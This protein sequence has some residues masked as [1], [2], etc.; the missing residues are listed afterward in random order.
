MNEVF[1]LKNA[2]TEKKDGGHS[3]NHQTSE[4]FGPPVDNRSE[5]IHNPPGDQSLEKS[6]SPARGAG[7]T[8]QQVYISH[9]FAHFF[10]NFAKFC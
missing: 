5:N 1:S 8:I 9:Y 4:Q 3:E 2:G 10:A 6:P 7:S